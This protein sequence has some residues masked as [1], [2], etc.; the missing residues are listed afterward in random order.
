MLSHLSFFGGKSIIV[1]SSE[2]AQQGDPLGPLLFS[3]TIHSML[4]RLQSEFKLFY[5]DD[6]TLGDSCAEDLQDLQGLEGSVNE[7]GLVANHR[8]AEIVCCDPSTV[9]TF[10]SYSPHFRWVKPSDACL[11]GPLIGDSPS[12]DSVLHSKYDALENMGERLSLLHSQDALL[13]LRKV[14]SLPKVLYVLRTTPCF[15][16]TI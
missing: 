5:L 4:I 12:I 7:L 8:K 9:N 13:L 15:E 3:L 1:D 6:G 2:G 10:P 16:S 14:S 11:L